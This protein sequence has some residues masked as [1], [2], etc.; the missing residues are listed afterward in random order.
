MTKIIENA[1]CCGQKRMYCQGRARPA[2]GGAGWSD[3]PS[4]PGLQGWAGGCLCSPSASRRV[5]ASEGPAHWPPAAPVGLHGAHLW[6][7]P[8]GSWSG[9]SGC[10]GICEH[11]C[12]LLTSRNAVDKANTSLCVGRADI[13][14]G[15]RDAKLL[16]AGLSAAETMPGITLKAPLPADAGLCQGPTPNSWQVPIC[17]DVREMML[18]TG[19]HAPPNTHTTHTHP[20]HGHPLVQTHTHTYTHRYTRTHIQKDVRTS[21]MCSSSPAFLLMSSA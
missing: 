19:A 7:S 11:A 2:R 12:K 5:R 10:P 3:L 9:K 1:K 13:Q 15:Q 8:S 20:R 16:R 18:G 14:L 4:L 21:T 6:V 17:S